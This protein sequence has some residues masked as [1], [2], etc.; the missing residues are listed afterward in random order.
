MVDSEKKLIDVTRIAFD[1]IVVGDSCAKKE[2][3][4]VLR[5]MKYVPELVMFLGGDDFS[6]D[7][8]IAILFSTT[9]R[10]Y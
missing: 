6:P 10:P 2:R 7:Q 8:S 5:S 3:N 4:L 1:E 9:G